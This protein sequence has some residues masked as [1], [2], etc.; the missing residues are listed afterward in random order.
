MIDDHRA[1]DRAAVDATSLVVAQVRE[2]HLDL[3]TPCTEWAVRD[4][5]RHMAGNNYG[6]AAAANGE[7]PD[8]IV[9]DG[10][11]L[12]EDPRAAWED[13]A[14][15]V[16]TAFTATD[17]LVDRLAIHGH[18]EVSAAQAVRMHFIDY[19]THGWDVAVSIGA[20]PRLDGNLCH[21]V[22]QI[23]ST[24]PA[25]HPAIWGPEAS[26]GFPVDVG[27]EASPCE[28][29]LGILGRSPTWPE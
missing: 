10:L 16:L 17:P 20:D 26:F 15:T 5:L 14:T 4:L 19:L 3:P 25:G 9:W 29:M 1:M 23:A 7:Q 13:S 8:P 27:V 22:L 28:R 12:P 2:S 21:E 24:W 11:N 18:G 6:F